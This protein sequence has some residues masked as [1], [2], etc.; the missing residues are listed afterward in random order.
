MRQT[1]I[2]LSAPV[3][4]PFAAITVTPRCS[5]SMISLERASGEVVIISNFKDD[6]KPFTMRS[7]ERAEANISVR[8]KSTGVSPCPNTKNEM[9]T[10]TESSANMNQLT[11]AALKCL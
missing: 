7:F 11:L 4:A 6:L 10:T 8:A 2:L 9:N 5:F 3:Y 1:S